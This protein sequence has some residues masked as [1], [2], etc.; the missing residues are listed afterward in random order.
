[1]WVCR[2]QFDAIPLANDG[3]RKPLALTS[4]N[5][6]LIIKRH[7]LL[8]AFI[9]LIKAIRFDNLECTSHSTISK[10]SDSLTDTRRCN[11]V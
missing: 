9:S 7:I 10:E 4:H 11:S 5:L 3:V 8:T 2:Q 1:M 6:P